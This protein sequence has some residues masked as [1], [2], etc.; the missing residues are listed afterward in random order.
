ME[1]DIKQQKIDKLIEYAVNLPDLILTTFIDIIKKLA[2]TQLYQPLKIRS[3]ARKIPTITNKQLKLAIQDRLMTNKKQY[4]SKTVLMA[5]Q[6]CEIG[7]MSYRSAVTC[8]KKVIEWLIDE[9]P[10]K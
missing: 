7:Q 9:E 5:T 2:Q 4:N 8:T 3:A 10:D 6:I 1:L